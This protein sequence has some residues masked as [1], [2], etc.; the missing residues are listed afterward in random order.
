MSTSK[1]TVETGIIRN[2]YTSTPIGS[3]EDFRA[4]FAAY[5]PWHEYAAKIANMVISD[6]PFADCEVRQNEAEREATDLLDYLQAYETALSKN[7]IQHLGELAYHVGRLAMTLQV[8]RVE[9]PA[10]LGKESLVLFGGH[11]VKVTSH[12]RR[13]LEFMGGKTET[14]IYEFV[15]ACWRAPDGKPK[16]FNTEDRARYDTAIS[17][18]NER[19]TDA[20]PTS[21][22]F[23]IRYNSVILR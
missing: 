2:E 7:Q 4:A 20:D 19:L 18:L 8:R 6:K 9:E 12:Q 5:V 1:R 11:W 13:I 21:R 10:R 17:R 16:R 3:R 15:K 22:T 14:S 23:S